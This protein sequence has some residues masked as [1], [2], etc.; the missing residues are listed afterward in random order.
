MSKIVFVKYKYT[1]LMECFAGFLA[2]KKKKAGFLFCLPDFH[3]NRKFC[4]WS[5]RKLDSKKPH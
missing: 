2:K 1:S 3:E 4:T 5:V